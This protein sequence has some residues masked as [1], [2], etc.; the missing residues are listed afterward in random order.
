[1]SRDHQLRALW[2]F[3]VR[4]ALARPGARM[5]LVLF[6]GIL[7]VGHLEFWSGK[8]E[9]RFFMEAACVGMIGLLCFGI[10]ED[11]RRHFDRYL[12]R[13]HIDPR[14]YVAVK[15]MAMIA[16]LLVASTIA[17][18]L[19]AAYGGGS[20]GEALW[21]TALATTFALMTAP[22]ALALEGYVDT[23]MP[24]AFVVLGVPVVLGIVYTATQSTAAFEWLGLTAIEPGSW[25]SLRPLMT[26]AAIG[27]LPAFLIAGALVELRLRRY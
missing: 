22:L 23:S 15:A 2:R 26:R 4:R 12:I 14:T 7:A 9:A 27:I 3:E 16:V 17:V 24:A 8:G 19:K 21:F 1:M 6:A 11:R 5:A 13:N 18:L 10:A 20:F 25:A